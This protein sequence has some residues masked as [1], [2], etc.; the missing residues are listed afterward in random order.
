MTKDSE[1][2]EDGVDLERLRETLRQFARERDWEQFRHPKN[3]A[4]T[5]A[6]E[7][8]ELLEI[9]Q[10]LSDE[11]SRN[12][13]EASDTVKATSLELA[14][15]VIYAVQLADAMGIDLEG[16]VTD[17]IVENEHRYPVASSKGSA[18]KHR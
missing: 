16:A 3:I 17:K 13:R 10:W 15:I 2:R 1:L 18:R 14:D 9:Y 5:L 8:G 7:T 4:M 6:G 11:E 12:A